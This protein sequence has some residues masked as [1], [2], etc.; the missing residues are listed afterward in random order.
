MPC[1]ICL[2]PKR[3]KYQLLEKKIWVGCIFLNSAYFCKCTQLF[4]Q[5]M[6]I[7]GLLPTPH[8]RVTSYRHTVTNQSF[9]YYYEIVL[10]Q[11][12]WA[13]SIIYLTF[14]VCEIMARVTFSSTQREF[15]KTG[16][17]VS[18]HWQSS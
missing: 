5:K 17:F 8:A 15:T 4:T 13:F 9:N 11:T 18:M 2:T 1:K 12:L 7:W 10:C 16:D 6:G 3:L 14:L